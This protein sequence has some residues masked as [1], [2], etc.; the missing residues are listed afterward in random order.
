MLTFRL[1]IAPYSVFNLANSAFRLAELVPLKSE[2]PVQLLTQKNV[3]PQFTVTSFDFAEDSVLPGQIFEGS[4]SLPAGSVHFS[5]N[6]RPRKV[7]ILEELQWLE[8]EWLPD[9]DV[10]LE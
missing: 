5:L 4:D 8:A 2:K 3:V 7:G 1:T 6:R 9:I 10:I